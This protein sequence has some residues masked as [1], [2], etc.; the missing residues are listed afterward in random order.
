M[1]AQRLLAHLL[2]ARREAAQE[3]KGLV[4]TSQVTM[5]KLAD[6]LQTTHEQYSTTLEV[7]TTDIVR[8]LH[9]FSACADIM[10]ETVRAGVNE[11]VTSSEVAVKVG[12]PI[13]TIH[14]RQLY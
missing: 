7:V 3:N 11:I 6:L 4:E 2:Q 13:H 14:C 10:Q 5:L 9:S 1:E 12:F 8:Y